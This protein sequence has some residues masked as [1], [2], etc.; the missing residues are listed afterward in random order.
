MTPFEA[1]FR[2]ETPAATGF[3]DGWTPA[4]LQWATCKSHSGFQC[5]TLIVPLDWSQPDG[6]QIGSPA[7]IKVSANPIDGAIYWVGGVLVGLVL[8]F[9]VVRAIVKGTSRVDE[10]AD[11]EAVTAAHEAL[12]DSEDRD[13]R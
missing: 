8:L 2:A 3:P 1:P 9:G 11:I 10:I 13:R 7:T 6:T 12:G 5:A 4:P